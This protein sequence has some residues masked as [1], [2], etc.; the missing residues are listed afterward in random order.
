[1]RN[2]TRFYSLS[3]EPMQ[4]AEEGD[5]GQE[6]PEHTAQ[7]AKVRGNAQDRAKGVGQ[8]EERRVEHRGKVPD[9]TH[10]GF[11]ALERGSRIFLGHLDEARFYVPWSTAHSSK[12]TSISIAVHSGIVQSRAVRVEHSSSPAVSSITNTTTTERASKSTSIAPTTVSVVV[13]WGGGGCVWIWGL[14]IE[15]NPGWQRGRSTSTDNR[16]G[17]TEN[18]ILLRQST[19][20]VHIIHFALSHGSR[21]SSVSKND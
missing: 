10:E 8:G 4:A 5:G 16:S 20:K 14:V 13:H 21:H 17:T 19:A 6:L 7:L 11:D 12:S 1:M 2:K 9:H 15:L 3:P 18:S